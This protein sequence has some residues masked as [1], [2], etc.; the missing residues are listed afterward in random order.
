MDKEKIKAQLQQLN[1]EK[2]DFQYYTFD[3]LKNLN[4]NISSIDI[5]KT[6]A[7]SVGEFFAE[8]LINSCY[9]HD[10]A[11]DQLSAQFPDSPK[12]RFSTITR[13]LIESILC[14]DKEC[15]AIA[16]H[17]FKDK[18]EEKNI[19]YNVTPN[20]QDK[21]GLFSVKLNAQ[22][23]QKTH[24]ITK[25]YLDLF[26]DSIKEALEKSCLEQ[27]EKMEKQRTII[28]A[29]TDYDKVANKINLKQSI[30]NVRQ[31]LDNNSDNDSTKNKNIV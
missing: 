31:K 1:Q 19:I 22:N 12:P 23:T 16:L 9:D 28:N 3:M 15:L 29:I 14:L 21:L 13:K 30:A 27:N 5:Q 18:L 11:L 25:K 6:V 4:V 24:H 10:F 17:T 26:T 7:L 20:N 8:K 2:Y